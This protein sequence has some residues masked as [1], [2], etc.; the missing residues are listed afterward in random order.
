MPEE[1]PAGARG[2]AHCLPGGCRDRIVESQGLRALRLQAA[3]GRRGAWLGCTTPQ[4][5][6]YSEPRGG[7][8]QGPWS[9]P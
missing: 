3:G 4:R 1:G 6:L 9:P 5:A 8:R 2:S 7:S